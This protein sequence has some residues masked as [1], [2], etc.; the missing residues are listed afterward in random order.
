M[1]R[2][3]LSDDPQVLCKGVGK[4]DKE[5]KTSIGFGSWEVPGKLSK[6]IFSKMMEAKGKLQCVHR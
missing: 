6:S 4:F 1:V 3:F 2:E 5:W